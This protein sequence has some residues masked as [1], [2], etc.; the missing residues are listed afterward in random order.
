MSTRQHGELP[1]ADYDHLPVGALEHRI[2]G[3]SREELEL[4]LQ[5]EREHADRR[6]V[7]E[8]F[9]ARLDQL[10]SGST[11][12]QGGDRTR[13]EQPGPPAK[14]SPVSPE[15]SPEPIH[16]PPHGTPATHAK[17]KGDRPS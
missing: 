9:T 10:K 16:P 15:T 8:L 2:R 5:Y 4:L 17:P 3:L 6:P 13:P 12:S 7:I 1:L 14:G 11:P